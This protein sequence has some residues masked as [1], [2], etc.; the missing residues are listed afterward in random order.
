[1]SKVE[2]LPQVLLDLVSDGADFF[3]SLCRH[4]FV[5]RYK[6]HFAQLKDNLGI[7][8]L[9]ERLLDSAYFSALLDYDEVEAVLDIE[10]TD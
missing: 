10:Y 5:H 8:D 2:A 9:V 3:C 7:S 1:M 6:V 4:V